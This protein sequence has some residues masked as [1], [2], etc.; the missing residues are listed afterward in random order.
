M[1]Y[2]RHNV[3]SVP[4]KHTSVSRNRSASSATRTRSTSSIT[5][6]DLGFRNS[7]LT[8]FFTARQSID[9]NLPTKGDDTEEEDEPN[10]FIGDNWSET[11]E[12]NKNLLIKVSRFVLFYII[13]VTVFCHMEGWSLQ[14]S[15]Y[16][17]TQTISTL[18]YGNI[19]PISQSARVFCA[20]YIYTG[21]VL[22]FSVI[23]EITHFMVNTM[24]RGYLTKKK[25]KLS[26]VQVI[27]RS[28]MNCLMWIFI[29]LVVVLVGTLVFSCNEGW[30][31]STAFYFS[32]YTASSVGYGNLFLTKSSSIWFNNFYILI[33][34]SI[35]GLAFEKVASF[36]RRLDENE[37]S[38]ILDDIEPS[39]QLINAIGKGKNKI[40]S[41]EY[42]LHMLQ[43]AG[44]LDHRKDIEPWMEKFREFDE[45]DDG[46]L[47]M[48]DVQAYEMMLKRRMSAKTEGRKKSVIDVITEETRAVLL[49]T[50]RLKKDETA[51]TPQKDNDNNIEQSNQNSPSQAQQENNHGTLNPMLNAKNISPLRQALMLRRA[52]ST[53]RIL[54]EQA[55]KSLSEDADINAI[56]LQNVSNKPFGGNASSTIDERDGEDDEDDDYKVVPKQGRPFS[57]GSSGTTPEDDQV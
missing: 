22:T 47:S 5:G 49:E 43:L 52:S 50:L 16:F 41:A 4:R 28:V 8:E 13:G 54:I 25:R 57:T 24:K 51:T 36:K 17:V 9:L 37:L 18:G 55:R 12:M 10:K 20:F 11:W 31:F 6:G 35:T 19:A 21:I 38:Q 56:E 2:N 32:A 3:T 39:V 46:Y 30:D 44:R 14:D 27:V 40:S 1:I 7:Y 15:I 53:N 45:D 48:A 26:R 33:S 34:I 42:I 23:G 29:L